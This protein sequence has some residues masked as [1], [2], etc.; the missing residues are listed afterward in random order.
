[1]LKDIIWCNRWQASWLGH[2]PPTLWNQGHVSN[3]KNIFPHMGI[4]IL[5]IRLWWRCWGWGGWGGGWGGVGVGGW[6][7]GGGGGG[8]CC[9]YI[10]WFNVCN[11]SDVY[12][13]RCCI[14]TIIARGEGTLLNLWVALASI[15]WGVI[16]HS[17]TVYLPFNVIYWSRQQR[18]L[19]CLTSTFS[20]TKL[21]YNIVYNMAVILSQPQC[22][23]VNRG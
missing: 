5:N 21:K 3:S 2:C 10:Q 1:M 12:D 11:L 18:V 4:P 19:L 17:Q 20:L 13:I 8:G 6:V 22:F 9:T 23:D 16:G 15:C 7:G 14:L